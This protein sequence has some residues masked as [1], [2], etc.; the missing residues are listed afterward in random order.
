MHRGAQATIERPLL[1]RL[2][3]PLGAPE[4]KETCPNKEKEGEKRIEV[5]GRVG[6]A[7]ATARP[8]MA[9]D[10]PGAFFGA[11]E[12]ELGRFGAKRM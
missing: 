3:G 1:G 5:T 10:G 2:L 6:P 7:G 8:K 9:K 4:N 11:H 12:T